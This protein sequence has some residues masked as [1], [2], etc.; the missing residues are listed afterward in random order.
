VVLHGVIPLA[1]IAVF[2]P[3]FFTAVGI[4]K[5][6]FS[7][8]TKLPPPF[9]LVGPIDGIGMGVG[10]LYLIYLYARH[11][12]RVQAT[13]RVFIEEPGGPGTAMATTAT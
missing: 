8:V 3:A 13:G 5:S 2:V 7:F 10:V 11:P 6:V 9:T 4:G 1:G 12:E